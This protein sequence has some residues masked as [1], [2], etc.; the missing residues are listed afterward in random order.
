MK[1]N[2]ALDL[3]HDGLGLLH[4]TTGGW[5]LVG[6]VSLDDPEMGKS[7]G[8]LRKTAAELET[9]GLSTKLIVPNSQILYK[10][11]EAPGPDDQSRE[12]Q[13]RKALDGLTPYDV[14][15]LKFDW[16]VDGDKVQVAAVA[17]ET[18]A[19]AEGFAIEHKLNPVCF[20]ASPEAGVFQGEAFFGT[21]RNFAR[22]HP[23][24]TIEQDDATVVVLGP[25]KSPVPKP[26][27]P[28]PVDQDAQPEPEEHVAVLTEK[29]AISAKP[30]PVAETSGAP[31]S[32]DATPSDSEDPQVPAG[33]AAIEETQEMDGAV[34]TP[35]PASK[36][37]PLPELSTPT[38]PPKDA[39]RVTGIAEDALSSDAAASLTPGQPEAPKSGQPFKPTKPAKAPKPKKSGS[40]DL[41]TRK[42]AQAPA[43]AVPPTAPSVEAMTVFGARK[44]AR[45]NPRPRYFVLVLALALILMLAVAA[46]LSSFVVGNGLSGLF[47]SSDTTAVV[48]NT[49]PAEPSSETDPELVSLTTPTVTPADLEDVDPELVEMDSEEQLPDIPQE[50]VEILVAP[51]SLQEA[52]AAFE[53]SGIWQR[54]PEQGPQPPES[55]LD[56]LY[57]ASI[58][59]RISSQDAIAL[60]SASVAPDDLRP[61][62]PISPPSVGTVFSLNDNGLVAPSA[63]GTLTPDGILVFAGRPARVPAGRPETE[64]AAAAPETKLAGLRPKSRPAGLVE[65]NEKVQLGGRLRSEL[66]ALK[67]KPRPKSAQQFAEQD[68]A[69]AIANDVAASV[70][71]NPMPEIRGTKLAIA[72][73]QRPSTKPSNIAQLADRA[74]KQDAASSKVQTAS[75]VRIPATDEKVDEGD[76]EPEVVALAPTIPS[77]ASVTRQ[78][79]VTRAIK[80][81][82]INL[83]GIYGTSSQRRALVRLASGKY[84]K[85]KVGDRVDGGK[86][87]AI[88]DDQLSYVKSGRNVVL[89]MPKG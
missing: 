44:V 24:E 38:A 68:L 60:P 32:P 63:Q 82:K 6:K 23:E 9:R 29:S 27:Q 5:T 2:F 54:A 66:A 1:P 18:L 47:S 58:D 51:M 26:V 8:Y 83:I 70:A 4:R 80:L 79:T 15:D 12:A 31:V 65:Q 42:I 11:V 57:V 45:Q 35:V 81:N 61:P 78:A 84:I 89:K 19:E 39:P 17:M 87:A 62:S 75:V 69:S 64:T 85:V 59:A 10:E 34:R 33:A 3:S 36:I 13:V 88:G 40:L 41:L 30:P 16:R 77:S 43:Q 20:V 72:Q 56:N 73:S 22:S 74:R 71:A 25:A 37:A 76:N 28:A 46:L 67:P 21:T 52:T 48:E 55:D 49:Q 14:A 86:V 53:A 7:I 50:P